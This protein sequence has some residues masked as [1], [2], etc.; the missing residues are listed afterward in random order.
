MTDVR[1]DIEAGGAAVGA[2]STADDGLVAELAARA[3]AG[4]MKLTGEGG[5]LEQL[6]PMFEDLIVAC[7][8]A[9]FRQS[10]RTDHRGYL[11][12]RQAMARSARGCERGTRHVTSPGSST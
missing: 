5:P 10:S 4:G 7:K 9:C 12:Q 2:T 3:Q 8:G 6:M 11:G 1:S